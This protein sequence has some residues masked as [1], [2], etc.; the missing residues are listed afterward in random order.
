MARARKIARPR[1]L[2]YCEFELRHSMGETPVD[3]LNAWGN[4]EQRV[5]PRRVA[6]CATKQRP[7]SMV[8]ARSMRRAL[9]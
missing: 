6:T 9:A 5:Q 1:N 3:C 8:L 7:T 4:A 2:C